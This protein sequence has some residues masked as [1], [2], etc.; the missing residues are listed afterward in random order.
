VVDQHR[1]CHDENDNRQPPKQA[2]EKFG[3]PH[4]AGGLLNVA[5]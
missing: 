2:V 5:P 4:I 1:S 3:A